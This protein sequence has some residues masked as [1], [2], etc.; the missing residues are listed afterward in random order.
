MSKLYSFHV[1]VIC[2]DPLEGRFNCN[3]NVQK[4]VCDPVLKNAVP[5]DCCKICK[6]VI[7]Y[8]TTLSICQ[9]INTRDLSLCKRCDQPLLH[10][11]RDG[12]LACFSLPFLHFRLQNPTDVGT[13]KPVERVLI[14]NK[15]RRGFNNFCD[16]CVID[17][18]RTYCGLE[19]CRICEQTKAIPKPYF[20]YIDRFKTYYICYKC[21]RFIEFKYTF[22]NE[23][24]T[25]TDFDLDN[26]HYI[27]GYRRYDV[28]KITS[29]RDIPYGENVKTVKTVAIARNV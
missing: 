7:S 26:M 6:D 14:S 10:V 4:C 2:A 8:P 17:F 18:T 21:K 3:E 12:N 15:N 13:G 24:M 23:D 29:T 11:H 19:K 28:C 22:P 9:L 25:Y 16:S 20:S 5:C 27:I 1:C